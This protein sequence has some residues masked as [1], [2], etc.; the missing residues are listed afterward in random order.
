MSAPPLDRHFALR[1]L[2]SLL[3]LLPIGAFLMF[4][5][6]ENS[7]ARYGSDYFFHHVVEKIDNMPYIQFMEIFVIA[8]PI[9]FHAIYGIIIWVQG[10]GNLGTY[11]YY[12]NWM[13]WMQRVSGIVA[14]LFIMLH[15]Y[16]TRIQVLLGNITK[17]EL[18]PTVAEFV[19]TPIGLGVYII[20]ILAAVIHLSNGLWLM[21]VT[22]GLTIGPR[23]QKISTYV[24]VCIGLLLLVFAGLSLSGFLTYDP[25][26]VVEAAA[27]H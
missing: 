7:L 13:Y 24:T 12:R 6:F 11:Q 20:G 14:I 3:G 19:Q 10:K 5:L 17:E 8:L 9:L 4:H 2:H 23:S 25:A 22:W 15:V 21:G 27:A 26:A 16:G 1:K 18:F